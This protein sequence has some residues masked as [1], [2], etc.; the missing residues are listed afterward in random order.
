MDRVLCSL[1][2]IS[3]PPCPSL[4]FNCKGNRDVQEGGTTLKAATAAGRKKGGSCAALA[5]LV[6]CRRSFQAS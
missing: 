1:G 2:V 3:V 6:Y 5:W 4:L